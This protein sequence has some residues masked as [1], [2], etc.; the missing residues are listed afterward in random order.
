VPLQSGSIALHYAAMKGQL[1]MAEL[2]VSQAKNPSWMVN[3]C[4]QVGSHDGV[5]DSE[6]DCGRCGKAEVHLQWDRPIAG[7]QGSKWL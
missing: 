7:P 4:D 3:V 5:C 2:L 6:W 1:E